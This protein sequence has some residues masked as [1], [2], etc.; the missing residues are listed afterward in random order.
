MRRTT[1]YLPGLRIALACSLIIMWSGAP[2]HATTADP[3][4]G[5]T[6]FGGTWNTNFGA[7]ALEPND[8][9]GIRFTGVMT[10]AGNPRARGIVTG[11][12]TNG[13]LSGTWSLGDKSGSFSNLVL[14]AQ[15][16]TFSGS[17]TAYTVWCGA[18]Q[19]KPLPAG[20]AFAGR[21]T[22]ELNGAGTGTLT[23]SQTGTSVSGSYSTKLAS[24]KLTGSVTF[25]DGLP[26][27]NGKWSTS[28]S[29]GLFK[30]YLTGFDARQFRGNFDGRVAF[31][32]WRSN[33]ARPATCLFR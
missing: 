1:S 26:V 23:L 14:D 15:G 10:D 33:T 4:Q 25:V 9:S 30:A 16:E 31:C 13:R 5:R 27:L 32:G 12:L 24:G 29:G 3:G 8:S 22:F 18:R 28:R 6:G 2:V 17:A 19:D 20:C 11:T 21:W 7:L